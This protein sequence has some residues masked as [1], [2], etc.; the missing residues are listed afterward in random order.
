MLT[1]QLCFDTSAVCSDVFCPL[2]LKMV[3]AQLEEEYEEKQGIAKEKRE[4][5]RKI[6]MM[7]DMK[8]TRDR[9]EGASQYLWTLAHWGLSQKV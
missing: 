5:E 2:Q 3:E 9:G 4:L 1:H 8:P 6:Q 7:N